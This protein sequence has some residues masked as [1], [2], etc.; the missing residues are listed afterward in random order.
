MNWYNNH[1]IRTLFLMFD[2]INPEDASITDTMWKN[3]NV[4]NK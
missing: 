2:L 1:S 3:E 4:K